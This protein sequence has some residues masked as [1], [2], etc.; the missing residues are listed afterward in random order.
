M[1]HGEVD[2]PK[3]DPGAA[4]WL[5]GQRDHLAQMVER[6][7]GLQIEEKLRVFLLLGGVNLVLCVD[8]FTQRIGSFHHGRDDVL[9]PELLALDQIPDGLAAPDLQAELQARFARKLDQPAATR[10][11]AYPR[12]RTPL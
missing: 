1:G 4:L 3:N 10:R 8:E 12:L 6:G 7:D 11:F 2:A 9:H 5:L